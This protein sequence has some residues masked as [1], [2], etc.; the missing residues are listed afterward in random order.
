MKQ[1]PPKSKT[2]NLTTLT[3]PKRRTKRTP[4]IKHTRVLK[5]RGGEIVTLNLWRG[6]E[7]SA[8]DW[9]PEHLLKFHQKKREGKQPK[10]TNQSRCR[11]LLRFCLPA[12]YCCLALLLLPNVASQKTTKRSGGIREIEILLPSLLLFVSRVY[13][14]RV[15]VGE[16]LA[17]RQLDTLRPTMAV[18]GACAQCR[19]HCSL[20]TRTKCS[21]SPQP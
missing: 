17:P 14:Y 10:R 3:R 16:R 18:V 6:G 1:H 20:S 15:S 7:I 13:C 5:I 8:T 12:W 2:K 9:N 4:R 19:N 11:W 21:L